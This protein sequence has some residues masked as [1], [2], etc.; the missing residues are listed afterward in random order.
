MSSVG[1]IASDMRINVL[2]GG[3]VVLGLVL[4]VATL[5]F[6]RSAV[7]DPE[8][9]APLEVMADRR[10]SRADMSRRIAMLNKV[11]PL[12]AQPLDQPASADRPVAAP[13]TVDEPGSN[14]HAVRRLR[15]P[16][17]PRAPRV[18]G[19]AAPASIDPLLNPRNSRE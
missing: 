9:L 15:A 5:S 16:Q 18:A 6:W 3:L 7:E 14:P 1:L 12:G 2:G 4:L 17:R 10:F 11:R 19:D 13:R 8:V